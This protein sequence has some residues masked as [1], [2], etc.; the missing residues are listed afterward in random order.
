MEWNTRAFRVFVFP[1]MST[2]NFRSYD[3]NK[4]NDI[5]RMKIMGHNYK[6]QGMLLHNRKVRMIKDQRTDLIEVLN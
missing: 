3:I 2:N 5:V 4:V 6:K 1:G